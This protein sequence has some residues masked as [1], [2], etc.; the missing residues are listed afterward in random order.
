MVE[1]R[2][3]EAEVEEVIRNYQTE[4]P[5]RHNRRNRYANIAG[6]RIRVTFDQPSAD[7][8]FVWTVTADEASQQ[9]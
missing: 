7:D 9:I 8:Y 6:R 1:R 3:T 2:V 5:A 4:I